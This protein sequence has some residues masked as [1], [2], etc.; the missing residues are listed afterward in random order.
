MQDEEVEVGAKRRRDAE[1]STS[2]SET[3][4]ADGA[5]KDARQEAKKDPPKDARLEAKKDPPKDAREAKKDPPKEAR[6]AKKDPP[7]DEDRKRPRSSDETKVHVCPD[8][9]VGHSDTQSITALVES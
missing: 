3:G 1:P 6:E 2:R 8:G 9:H 7:K 4:R 5:K